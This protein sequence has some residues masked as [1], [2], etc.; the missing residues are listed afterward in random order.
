MCLQWGRPGFSPWVGTIPWRRERLPTPVFWP[1][2][3]HGLY[4]PWGPKELDTT[5]Q[6]LLSLSDNLKTLHQSLKTSGYSLL[7]YTHPSLEYNLSSVLF[8]RS[9]VSDSLQPH[10]SQHARPPY[11][12]PTPRIYSNSCPLSWSCHPTISSPSL[13]TLN[14]PQHQGLFKWVSSSNQVAKVLEFQLQ[15]QSFQWISRTDFLKIDWLDLL[16][17]QGTLKSLLQHHSSKASILRC[18]ASLWSNS[19]IHTWLLEKTIALT[20]W[21]F[22]S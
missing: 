17:T 15:H 8:S 22:V 12:S 14:I 21:S 11:P 1:G 16:A 9:V 2:K 19:H 5:E 4:S 10:E 20:R 7:S 6:L 18:S 13:P 3:F